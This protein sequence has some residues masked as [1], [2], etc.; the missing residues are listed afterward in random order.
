MNQ[1]ACVSSR[2]QFVE[3]SV[4][5]IDRYCEALLPRLGLERET[6]SATGRPIPT[7]LRDE[8][9]GLRDME[10]YYRVWG[11]YDGRG[12]VIRS[13]EPVE[14]QPDGKMVNVVPVKRL[15]DALRYVNIATQ[16][17]GVFPSSRKA[18]LRDLLAA[19]G[20]QRVVELGAAGRVQAGLPHDG[21][22]PLSRFVRW[23]N[24]E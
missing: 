1:Q 23:V 24:D 21:F 9:D 19:A 12:L 16:T 4:E 11:S 5:E 18:G 17:I 2:I 14:F 15:E 8:I 22:L 6:A 13:D 10:P 3:G 20:A 7:D